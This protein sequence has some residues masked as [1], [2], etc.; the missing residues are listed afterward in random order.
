MQPV[1]RHPSTT[2]VQGLLA[3]GGDLSV[4]RLLLA[5]HY[6][7]FPWYNPDS[8]ILWWHP[9]PRCVLYPDR[10][11]V[12]KSMRNYFNQ[13]RFKVTVDTAFDDVIA[14]CRLIP[15][16]GQAGTWLSD[17]MEA[18]YKELHCL[19]YARSVEVWD[20]EGSLVGGLYGVQIADVFFGESMFSKASNASKY[21]LITWCKM[22]VDQG[23]RLI[24]CQMRTDHL[25]R[26]GA[27]MISRKD[28]LA[29]LRDNR[30]TWL[31]EGSGDMS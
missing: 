17:E 6:G 3:V 5:Y 12:S 28:F 14:A 21:G 29:I 4:D 16:H 24:D 25:I 1:F 23:C 8:P 13:E 26:M 15:R 9:E 19:G 10:V 30:L 2:N 31:G 27:E 18:A 7:I 11:R 22:L 20:D